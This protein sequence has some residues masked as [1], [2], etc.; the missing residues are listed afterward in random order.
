VDDSALTLDVAVFLRDLLAGST[1][2]VGAPDF[3]QVAPLAAKAL[4]QLNDLVGVSDG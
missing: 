3:E 2:R 1:L 4:A